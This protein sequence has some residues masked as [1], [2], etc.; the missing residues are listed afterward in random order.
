MMNYINREYR[1]PRLHLIYYF[2]VYVRY[3]F[4]LL[5][6]IYMRYMFDLLK[7]PLKM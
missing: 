4:N 1:I 5:K 2:N 3:M 6:E 7:E